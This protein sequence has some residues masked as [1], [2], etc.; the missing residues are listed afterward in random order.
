MASTDHT[1]VFY[2]LSTCVH[3]RHAREFLEEHN[4]QFDLH[5]VDLAEGDERNRLLEKVR[6]CNPGVSFPTIVVDNKKV[7]VGF[8]PDT[9]TEA[10]EL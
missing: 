7:I 9:L 4:V 8:Q 10:L 3:C 2:G 1:C 5:Y 6:G